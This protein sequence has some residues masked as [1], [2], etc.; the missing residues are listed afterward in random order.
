MQSQMTRIFRQGVTRAFH[1]EETVKSRHVLK[2]AHQPIHDLKIHEDIGDA[3]ALR[4]FVAVAPSSADNQH[5]AGLHPMMKPSRHVGRGAG[6]N[7]DD[8]KKVV[9][10]LRNGNLLNIREDCHSHARVVAVRF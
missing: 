9:P 10:M 5:F 1:R 8:L 6:E 7:G 3:E 2:P 4:I